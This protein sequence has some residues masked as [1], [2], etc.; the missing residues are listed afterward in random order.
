[1]DWTGEH[2]G[3][4]SSSILTIEVEEESSDMIIIFFYNNKILRAKLYKIEDIKERS[5]I[6]II[7][8]F[9]YK[10]GIPR[11]RK[12]FCTLYGKE[13]ILIE[14]PENC[15]EFS[16]TYIEEFISQFK[17]KESLEFLIDSIRSCIVLRLLLGVYTF[18]DRSIIIRYDKITKNVEVISYYESK[19]NLKGKTLSGTMIE[20]W[21]SDTLGYIN[22][23]TNKVSHFSELS[24]KLLE[25]IN[26]T[27]KKL[28]FMYNNFR[29]NCCL[30]K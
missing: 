20:K 14:Y 3:N 7:E 25:S 19:I 5:S 15:L 30:L 18:S 22:Y 13:Y 12:I 11:P 27:D 17:M 10:C 23:F 4:L 9:K 6:A 29:K 1:M 24:D 16:Y 28:M 21:F 26:E 8:R 2:V